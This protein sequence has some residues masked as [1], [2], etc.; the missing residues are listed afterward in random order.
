MGDTLR[1]IN[2]ESQ[3]QS[4]Q[5]LYMRLMRFAGKGE[6]PGPDFLA[7]WYRRN[8]RIF[9]NLRNI[10]D[11]PSDRVLVVYGSGHAYW[12]ERNTLDS[13]DLMLERLSAYSR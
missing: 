11:S 1:Y 6:Y 8:A 12:L 7:E 10:I 4:D 13:D 9:S 2:Q 3:V 5:A